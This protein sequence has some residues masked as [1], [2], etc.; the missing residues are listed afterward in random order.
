M[1]RDEPLLFTNSIRV[2]SNLQYI[3]KEKE[4][5]KYEQAEWVGSWVSHWYKDRLNEFFFFFLFVFFFN[6]HFSFLYAVIKKKE[7]Q[8]H[9]VLSGIFDGPLKIRPYRLQSS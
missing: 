1:N 6:Y 5:Q 8:S 7:R 4:E 3:Y 9:G 2:F